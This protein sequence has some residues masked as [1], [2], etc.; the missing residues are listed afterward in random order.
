MPHGRIDWES[1]AHIRGLTA[2]GVATTV[3]VDS[4]GQLY[5]LMKGKYGTAYVP[6]TVDADGNLV[7]VMKGDYEGAL[8]T[9]AIDDQGRI[10]AVLTDPEDVFGNPSYMGAAE[11]AARLGSINTFE[12]R[13]QTVWMDDFEAAT[14]KWLT[15]GSGSGHSEYLSNEQARIGNTSFKLTTGNAI[16]NVSYIEKTFPLP[17]STK[18]G[19]EYSFDFYADLKYIQLT[20][21]LY[22]GVNSYYVD[23]RYDDDTQKLQY[24]TGLTSWGDAATGLELYNGTPTWHTLKVVFDI[25]TKKYIRLLLDDVEYDLSGKTLYSGANS[26]AKNM[27]VRI[28]ITTNTNANN[29]AYIDTV[30]I[31]QNESG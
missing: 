5:A 25:E 27:L 24:R 9:L 21:T 8:K 17:R 19:V 22:D 6:V 7:S 29:Y 11:L 23:V 3:L 28:S 31:T 2:D 18:V 14:A 10:L 12:R 26:A 20:I 1:A 4:Q 13:G 15:Y 30:I 16:G